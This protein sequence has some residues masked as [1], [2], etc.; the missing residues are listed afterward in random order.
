MALDHDA[1]N[2]LKLPRTETGA[3]P[4]RASRWPKLP[5]KRLWIGVIVILVVV[6]F[7]FK[8]R[9]YTVT[10]TQVLTPPSTNRPTVLNASGYVIARRLATVA[11][12]VTGRL[13]EVRV[14]EGMNVKEGQVLARLDPATVQAALTQALA[15]AD[16]AQKALR[17]IEVR[18]QDATRNAQRQ[19]ELLNRHLVAQSVADTATAD[20]NALSARLHVQQAE[21]SVA[22]AAVKA[23][24]QDLEDLTIR[25]PFDGVVITK[26]AQPGEMV[27]PISAGGGFTRTGIATVVDMSSRELEVDVNESFIQKVHAGQPVEASLDAYPDENIN[28][29]VRTV[30]PTADRQKATVKVR[31]VMEH[32]SPKILPDMGVKVRFLAEDTVDATTATALVPKAALVTDAGQTIVFVLEAGKAH[33][34]VVKLGPAFAD[35]Q[36]IIAGVKPSEHVIINPPA[37]LADGSV[38]QVAS[39]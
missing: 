9:S 38:A 5:S 4:A 23:R 28:A 35:D 19:Q 29:H 18:L 20:M 39:H 30:V 15:G 26:D 37:G 14:D 13:V 11:S 21:V 25:A 31:I 32:L 24:R 1:L 34:R 10:E 12:K 27:S 22:E 2:A 7:M 36:L 3:T 17:E 8:P 33:R 6:G 16:S